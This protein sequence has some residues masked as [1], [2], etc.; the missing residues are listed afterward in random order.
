MKMKYFHGFVTALCAFGFAACVAEQ[1]AV[2]GNDPAPAVTIFSYTPDL[3]YNADN[4]IS[5]RFA[6]NEQTSDAYYLAEPTADRDARV[7]S[8][9]ENGYMD[10]VVSNGER[11]TG[12]SGESASDVILTD[13]M[14]E[15]TITAV[16]VGNGGKT[17]SA[18]SF[19]GLEWENIV[20]GTYYFGAV[21]FTSDFE[22]RPTVLQKC[23]SDE[24]LYR[25]KDVFADGYSL[26]INIL[27]GYTA[28]DEDGT[29]RF[30]RIAAQPT[31]Y[32]YGSYGSVYIRDIGYWQG[33]DAF[34]TNNGYES[35]MYEDGYCFL[36]AQYY[37]SA[38]SLGYGYDEFVPGR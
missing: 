29:Y 24:T 30:F 17:A 11:L 38:G 3:P 20:S 26:K 34:V 15:Y 6:T 27:P 37:V 1:G 36:C 2:P 4:D 8:V 25:F 28:T 23:T 5:L 35:G 19:T 21:A 32:T 13:L 14:G 7:A 9:G 12:I 16:A 18:I 10:Y 22:P 31:P 33:N